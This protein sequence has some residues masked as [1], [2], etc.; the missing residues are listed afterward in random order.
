M[1]VGKIT[2]DDRTLK[3][4]HSHRHG[5]IKKFFPHAV[6]NWGSHWYIYTAGNL[7]AVV[8]KIHNL[9]TRAQKFSNCCSTQQDY[10]THLLYT[11]IELEG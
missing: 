5:R 1:Q 10:E 7:L 2:I 11:K 9:E 6:Q 3:S 4:R 8:N